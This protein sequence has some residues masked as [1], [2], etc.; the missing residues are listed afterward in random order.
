MFVT[1]HS[2]VFANGYG[3][4]LLQAIFPALVVFEK[5]R[6]LFGHSCFSFIAYICMGK[7]YVSFFFVRYCAC[8]EHDILVLM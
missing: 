1:W 6:K 4:I 7:Y 2:C 3:L 5:P 8:I